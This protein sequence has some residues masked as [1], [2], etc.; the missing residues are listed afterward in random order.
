LVF[1]AVIIMIAVAKGLLLQL[2]TKWIFDA[3]WG[4]PDQG[5]LSSRVG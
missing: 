2:H 4:K 3:K 5:T 1:C